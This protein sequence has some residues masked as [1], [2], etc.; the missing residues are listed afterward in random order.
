MKEQ[1][2]KQKWER[3]K[4]KKKYY[5]KTKFKRNKMKSRK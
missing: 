4:S 3:C 5:E 2:E 1:N